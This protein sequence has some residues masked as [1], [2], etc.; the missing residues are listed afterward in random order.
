MDAVREVLEQ[1]LP[2]PTREVV[3]ADAIEWLREQN[4]LPYAVSLGLCACD[5]WLVLV[6]VLVV[7]AVAVAVAVLVLVLVVKINLNT[8]L[9]IL[10]ML[11]QVITSI[12]DV[13]EIHGM[14]I[15]E[16]KPWFVQAAVLILQRLMVCMC[17]C[18]CTC[19]VHRSILIP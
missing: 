16:Y 18:M 9:M 4:E 1:V 13:I 10:S 5:K 6:L 19:T 2:K 8:Q 12:P 3:C 15:E 11:S 17:V 14:S 7:V